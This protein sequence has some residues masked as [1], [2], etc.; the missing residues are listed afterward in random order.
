MSEFPYKQARIFTAICALIAF[1]F[2]ALRHFCPNFIIDNTVTYI[3][4]LAALPWLKFFF[5]EIRLPGGAGAVYQD[6]SQSVSQTPI[7]PQSEPSMQRETTDLSLAAKKIIAT[8]WKYQKQY[9]KDDISKRW[10]F[11]VHPLAQ[12]YPNYLTGLGELVQRGFVSVSPE[13]QHCM[14]TNEGINFVN[15]NPEL[16]SYADLYSF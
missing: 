15:S 1:V 16:Q 2:L 12:G 7:P 8:L 13:N 3:L 9:F 6:R 11:T 10:T 4:I 5:K 14:L